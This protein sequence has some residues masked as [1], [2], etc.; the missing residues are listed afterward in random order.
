MKISAWQK[1]VLVF[2]GLILSLALLE[3]GFRLGGFVQLSLHEYGNLQSVKQKSTYRILCLGDS[4]TQIQ[5]PILLDQVLN[6]RNIGVRFSIIDPGS[7]GANPTA[8]ILSRVESY[9]TEYRPDMVIAM[10]GDADKG[11]GH[12]QDLSKDDKSIFR[13]F[14]LYQFVRMRF[15]HAL[16]KIK[17]ENIYELSGSHPGSQAKPESA[18][19]VT[20]KANLSAGTSAENVTPLD[21]RSTKGTQRLTSSYLNDGEISRTKESLKMSNGLHPGNDIAYVESGRLYKQQD[22]FSEAENSYRKAIEINPLDSSAYIGLG[23]LYKDYGKFSQAED[24]FKKAIELN[25][26]SDHAYIELGRLYEKWGM[27]SRAEDAYKKA[28]ELNPANE[29]ALVELGSLYRD[30]GELA[31]AEDLCKRAIEHN[32][33]KFSA[34]CLLGML[35]RDQG[36]LSQAED[37]FRR[38]LE[39]N[40][41]RVSERTLRAMASLYEEMGKPELAKEYTEKAYHLSL[42]NNSADAD[43]VN[44]YR[45]LK[46]ILDRKGIKL[47]CV[48][49][50]MRN[51]E[52][53]KSIFGKDN[54]VIFVDNEQVFK[55]AI[56]RSGYKEYFIDVFAGDFGHCT[57]KGNMLL[58]QNIA[59]VILREVF[60]K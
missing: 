35:Y 8:I 4:M 13:H 42:G 10:L 22:K 18:G 43:T 44:S 40:P 24:C 14:L 6:E 31:Q 37:S 27:L 58:A 2:L 20:G 34:L 56:K 52:P 47:V 48:Q 12:S 39:L 51:V 36:K 26:K 38:A 55:E 29:V 28:L 17:H 1:T 19:I 49:Y 23:R 3:A 50:P 9:L 16:E 45:K 32:P 11:S 57:R 53:L 54:G 21:L 46:E 41:E 30:Q 60:N 7:G 25:P 15:M 59:D 33:R 5:Y